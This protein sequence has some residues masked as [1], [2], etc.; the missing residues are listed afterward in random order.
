MD[1]FNELKEALRATDRDG[2]ESLITYLEQSTFLEMPASSAYHGNYKGGLLDHVYNVWKM[3]EKMAELTPSDVD[4]INP[5]SYLIAAVCHDLCKIGA[6]KVGYRNRKNKFGDWEKYQVYEPADNGELPL[7][8]SYTSIDIAQRYIELTNIEKVMIA[9]HMG[10][11][12]VGYAQQ[13]E[14]EEAFKKHPEA[15]ILHLADMFA[16]YVLEETIN[17]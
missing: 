17:Y 13:R 7:G 10:A 8:H 9:N 5:Q 14:V 2:V 3:A 16:S 4:R 11:I 12:G 6:Y 1:K 15:L